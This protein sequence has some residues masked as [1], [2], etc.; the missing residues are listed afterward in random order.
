[1]TEARQQEPE[2]A[3]GGCRVSPLLEQDVDD[4]MASCGGPAAGSG[5]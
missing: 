3:L 5:F 1:M 2:E 4:L